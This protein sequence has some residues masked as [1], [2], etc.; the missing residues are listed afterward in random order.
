MN[1]FFYLRKFYFLLS[2]LNAIKTRLLFILILNFTFPSVLSLPSVMKAIINPNMK[3][4][5]EYKVNTSDLKYFNT[6][7][8]WRLNKTRAPKNFGLF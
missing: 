1:L 8:L 6:H 5:N 2:L 7:C 3:R 4:Y